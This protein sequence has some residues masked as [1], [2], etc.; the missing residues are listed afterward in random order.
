MS[1]FLAGAIREAAL[2]RLPVCAGRSTAHKSKEERTEAQI[3][4]MLALELSSLA[5]SA[6]V[7]WKPSSSV[8]VSAC[9]KKSPVSLAVSLL[10]GSAL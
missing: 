6:L 4:K 5:G 10:A 3:F 1:G 9:D 2:E 8:P 7:L